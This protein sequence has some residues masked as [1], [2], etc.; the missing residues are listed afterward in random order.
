MLCPLCAESV[1]LHLLVAMTAKGPVLLSLV[2]LILYEG[3]D[4]Q[5][6]RWFQLKDLL[7]LAS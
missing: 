7:D 1:A 3:R 6:L 2:L 4:K 5:L